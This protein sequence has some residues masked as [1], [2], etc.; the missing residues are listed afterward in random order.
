VSAEALA[1]G[2]TAM[3]ASAARNRFIVPFSLLPDI[4]TAEL[5]YRVPGHRFS[6]DADLSRFDRLHDSRQLVSFR[7]RLRRVQRR[8]ITYWMK[9]TYFCRPTDTPVGYELEV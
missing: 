4:L 2:T 5:V 8:L 9:R 1:I 3:I 6:L 7:S